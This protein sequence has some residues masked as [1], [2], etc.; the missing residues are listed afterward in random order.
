MSL[1][2]SKP[3]PSTVYDIDCNY[4]FAVDGRPFSGNRFNLNAGGYTRR[5]TAEGAIYGLRVGQK[6]PVWYDPA[7][8]AVSVL[9]NAPPDDLR[10]MKY[11]TYLAAATA[12]AGLIL[13]AVSL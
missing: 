12:V 4:D 2:A 11:G 10:V 8:P 5:S 7:S 9:R 13:V 6:V 3:I 1:L